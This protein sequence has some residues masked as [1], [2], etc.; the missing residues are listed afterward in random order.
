MP[1]PSG[2]TW[3]LRKFWQCR[4]VFIQSGGADQFVKA[5]KFR[6]QRLYRFLHDSGNQVEWRRIICNSRA[7]PKSTFI[8]WLAVQNRLATKDRLL[9]WNLSIQSSCGLCQMHDETLCHLFFECSYAKQIWTAVL[10]ELGIA[11]GCLSWQEELSW[12]AKKSRS[13]RLSHIKCSVAFIETV[14]AVW[15]QSCLEINWSL[16]QL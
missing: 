14:Y 5:G 11:R 2:L 9:G 12:V 10:Q 15:I 7:R 4:D 1:I 6:I 16:F 8:V 13:N 3:S